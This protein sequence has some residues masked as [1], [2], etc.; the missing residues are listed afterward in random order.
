MKDFISRPG[1]APV[2]FSSSDTI[3]GM[4]NPGMNTINVYIDNVMGL[5]ASQISKSLRDE[6]A[7]KVTI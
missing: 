1:Q 3:I 6:L 5:S 7:R 2:P 4:K